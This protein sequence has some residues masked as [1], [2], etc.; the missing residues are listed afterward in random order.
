MLASDLNSVAK[1]SYAAL[2]AENLNR[3]EL[4]DKQSNSSFAAPKVLYL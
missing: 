4:L 1:A 2:L 3:F